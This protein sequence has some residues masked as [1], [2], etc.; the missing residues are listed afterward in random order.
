MV[1]RTGCSKSTLARLLLGFEKP[2]KGAVYYDGR[3][4]NG[5][6]LQSLRRRIGTVTQ[7]AGL[8]QGNIYSN[9][10]ISAPELTLEDAW[11]AAEKAGIADDIRAMPMGI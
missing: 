9:I 3:D 7:D 2:E 4:I 11:E 10:V 1:G 8:F 5:L 6:D